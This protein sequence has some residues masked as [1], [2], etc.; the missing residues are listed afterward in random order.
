M[1]VYC[2]LA[3]FD[4]ARPSRPLPPASSRRFGF[5]LRQTSQ[6]PTQRETTPKPTQREA[7]P[8]PTHITYRV[9]ALFAPLRLVPRSRHDR[10]AK[11]PLA[12]VG[13]VRSVRVMAWPVNPARRMIAC[14][15]LRACG[16]R[17]WPVI[18]ASRCGVWALGTPAVRHNPMRV[19]VRCL[20]PLRRSGWK[21]Y[22][23][24]FPSVCDYIAGRSP[25]GFHPLRTEIKNRNHD[26]G[27]LAD[28][29]LEYHVAQTHATL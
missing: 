13:E 11:M 25:K 27:T 26:A 7:T 29:M 21:P 9:C 10:C 4:G 12:W 6:L 8:K 5:A 22:S 1:L 24:N 2:V 14:N 3:P 19:M 17:L 18:L 16:L 23:S 20:A 15:A 28:G